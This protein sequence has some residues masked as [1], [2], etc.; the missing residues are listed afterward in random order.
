[1]ILRM[2]VQDFYVHSII[3]SLALKLRGR[4]CSC[5]W[6]WCQ[7]GMDMV[8]SRDKIKMESKCA[9]QVKFMQSYNAI[10]ASQP[11]LL[12]LCH[13]FYKFTMRAN[14]VTNS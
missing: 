10:C 13:Y 7:E 11:P 5:R 1:M 14:K 2:F 3:V 6:G 8:I 4:D 9:G 12:L